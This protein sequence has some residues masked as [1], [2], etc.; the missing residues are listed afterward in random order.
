MDRPLKLGILFQLSYL[1]RV[2][3]ERASFP[4]CVC[5]SSYHKNKNECKKH[6]IDEKESYSEYFPI[7]ACIH[8]CTRQSSTYVF[9]R[10]TK[11]LTFVLSNKK[12]WFCS[13]LLLLL[14]RRLPRDVSLKTY[15][16]SS[17]RIFH[18]N[19]TEICSHGVILLAL[20]QPLKQVQVWIS[21]KVNRC[22]CECS[23]K[24]VGTGVNTQ[25][26]E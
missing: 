25:P 14:Y 3:Y 18:V 2:N 21:N 6:L 8:S 4:L 17:H 13:C 24:Q 12:H 5:F 9:S 7:L 22:I 19:L 16:T 11:L 15:S 10:I 26:D 1:I 23:A 20:A